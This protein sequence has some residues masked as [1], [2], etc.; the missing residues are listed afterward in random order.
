M[1]AQTTK[2]VK[3][4]KEFTD[5]SGKRWKVGDTYTGSAEQIQAAKQAGQVQDAPA[6]PNAPAE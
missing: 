6:D 5:N 1:P 3:V 2:A 4:T